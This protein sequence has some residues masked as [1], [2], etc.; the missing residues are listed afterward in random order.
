MSW[1]SEQ[2]LDMPVVSPGKW[3]HVVWMM[4]VGLGAAC[5]WVD[6]DGDGVWGAVLGVLTS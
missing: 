3:D 5:G 6:V 4:F 1:L 2:G